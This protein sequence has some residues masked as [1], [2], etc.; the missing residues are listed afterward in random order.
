MGGVKG[1]WLAVM[2]PRGEGERLVSF[3]GGA[4]LCY[5]IRPCID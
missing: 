4:I 5:K 2:A 3:S 1:G